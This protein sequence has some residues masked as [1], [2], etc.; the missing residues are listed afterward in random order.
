[1]PRPAP[2]MNHTCFSVIASSVVEAARPRREADH[3]AYS[4]RPASEMLTRKA[5]VRLVEPL[6]PAANEGYP[7]QRF[8]SL[9]D[10]P[11]LLPIPPHYCK[12][13]ALLTS[14]RHARSE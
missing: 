5:R 9:P 8:N 2:V 14:L 1:M 12:D 10:S 3:L 11:L 13:A 6:V 7:N 4:F